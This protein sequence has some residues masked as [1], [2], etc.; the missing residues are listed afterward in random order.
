LNWR[1]S[2]AHLL[3]MI[4]IVLTGKE[5]VPLEDVGERSG[6]LIVKWGRFL[7]YFFRNGR[8]TV[9]GSRYF[10]SALNSRRL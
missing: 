2:H 10:L 8:D 5:Q 1:G 4:L 6:L 9:Q 3:Q 7:C